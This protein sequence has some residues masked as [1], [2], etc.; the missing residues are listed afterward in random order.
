MDLDFRGP[1]SAV[2][3]VLSSPPSS[4]TFFALCDIGFRAQFG[5]RRLVRF[6]CWLAVVSYV[7]REICAVVVVVVV[8][9]F[10][11]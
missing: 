1:F 10:F 11:S 4:L 7:V 8:V 6:C 9:V 5:A 2:V 3:I